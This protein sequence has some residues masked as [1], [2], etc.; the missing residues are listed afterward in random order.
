MDLN[1][2][3]PVEEGIKDATTQIDT[4]R[5]LVRDAATKVTGAAVLTVTLYRRPGDG[6]GIITV[7]HNLGD[8]H[9]D[10]AAA[11]VLLAGLTLPRLTDTPQTLEEAGVMM[12]GGKRYAQ[13]PVSRI[14]R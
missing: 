10:Q 8:D 6:A 11:L 3:Q 13:D 4:F 12:R 5:D 7:D 9:P 1:N 2:Q 14:I